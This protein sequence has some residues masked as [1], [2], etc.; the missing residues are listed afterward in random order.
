LND[1]EW[2]PED[3]N[4]EAMQIQQMLQTSG[5]MVMRDEVNQRKAKLT[6][7]LIAENDEKRKSELQAN[8]R[9]LIFLLSFPEEMLEAARRINEAKTPE[10]D[11]E[12]Q[13][14]APA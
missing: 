9:S 5:W 6:D 7:L 4:T 3:L 8:I 14:D 12:P 10:T 2:T 1:K 11:S 13:G